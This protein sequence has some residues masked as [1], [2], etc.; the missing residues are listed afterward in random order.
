MTMI[1]RQLTDFSIFILIFRLFIIRLSGSNIDKS[2]N[3]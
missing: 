1:T 2:G 3:R